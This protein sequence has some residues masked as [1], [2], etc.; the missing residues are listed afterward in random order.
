[1]F[2]LSSVFVDA[3]DNL[4]IADDVVMPSNPPIATVEKEELEEA[5]FDRTPFDEVTLEVNISQ[6]LRKE[7]PFRRMVRTQIDRLA[8]DR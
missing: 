3:G 6:R 1:L 8:W 5:T 2:L 4:V 7:E